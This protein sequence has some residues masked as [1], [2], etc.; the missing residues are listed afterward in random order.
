MMV[1]GL[2]AEGT[3]PERAPFSVVVYGAYFQFLVFAG[4]L[5]FGMW[6]FSTPGMPFVALFGI[7]ALVLATFQLPVRVTVRGTGEL[8]F[9]CL[10][11]VRRVSASEIE[12]IRYPRL[13]RT[14]VVLRR[15][16]RGSISLLLPIENV[17]EL[18]ER[19]RVLNAEVRLDQPIV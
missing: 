18:I 5:A 17:A 2:P 16:G 15:R 19:V 4:V 3:E 12:S 7:V 9:K 6:N 14:H 8:E 10:L 1:D 13:R 11:R